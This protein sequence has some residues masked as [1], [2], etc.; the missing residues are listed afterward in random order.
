[1]KPLFVSGYG[2]NF[3]VSDFTLRV[4]SRDTLLH[5]FAPHQIPFDSIILDSPFGNISL[6]ALRWLGKHS[7]PIFVMKYTGDVQTLILPNQRQNLG[8]LKLKQL[9]AFQDE[10]KRFYIAREF[11]RAKT[12]LNPEGNTIS[13]LLG[14]EGSQANDYFDSIGVVRERP[15]NDPQNALFNYAYGILEAYCRFAINAHGLEPSIGFLHSPTAK[16]RV[17]QLKEPKETLVYDFQELGRSAFSG[18]SNS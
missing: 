11:V 13:E 5:E 10:R 8:Y 3:S 12:G 6:E 16:T 1:M 2:I 15:A 7:I 17:K 18:S 9:E 4:K 14:F